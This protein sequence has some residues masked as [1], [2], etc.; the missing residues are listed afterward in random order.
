MTD[1]DTPTT[2]TPAPAPAGLFDRLLTQANLTTALAV[3]AVVLAATP[4]VVPQ[5]QAWQVR[6]GLLERP[7]M[8]MDAETSLQQKKEKAELAGLAESA[9]SHM[10]SLF[11]DPADPVLGNPNAPIK[12][13][14]FLDYNCIHCRA[15][16]A[17]LKAYL[18]ANPD[19]ALI[20]KE[21][22]VISQNS[23]TLALYALAAAKQGKYPDMHYA[24]MDSDIRSQGDLEAL[25]SKVGLDVA[26]TK[27][28]VGSDGLQ[29]HLQKSFQL[30]QDLGIRGTPTFIVG[31]TPVIG[32][33][34]KD[35]EAVVTRLRAKKAG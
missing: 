34:M 23:P 30:G 11:S 31:D 9:K 17:D 15:V 26:A 28:L 14:E 19:V 6:R 2:E 33:K 4:Y 29:Q 21:Y 35:I 10:Q 25:V 24:L 3:V 32:E 20:V 12:I 5:V 16:N 8:L 18:A 1:P 27:A 13:V 7:T 22:P